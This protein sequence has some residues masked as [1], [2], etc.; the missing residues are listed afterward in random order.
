[1]EIKDSITPENMKRDPIDAL[2]ETEVRDY[3]RTILS[4][5]KDI[6]KHFDA[7]FAWKNARTKND[8]K[9]I[10]TRSMQGLRGAASFKNPGAV[11]RA[12]EPVV[13][14]LKQAETA[15]QEGR[16]EQSFQITQAVLEKL[17]PSLRTTDDSNGWIGAQID[18]A[19]RLQHHLVEY[20]EDRSLSKA[21][22]KW[23]MQ[24][25]P[26]AD[27]AGW[28]CA[29]DFAHLAATL[30]SPKQEDVIEDLVTKMV[31]Q[32][33][34][35]EWRTDF[36]SER[37]TEVMYT[38]SLYHKTD[39]ELERFIDDNLEVTSIREQA[40]RRAFNKNDFQRAVDLCYE[41]V[42][43]AEKKNL[44]GVVN[45]WYRALLDI[46]QKQNDK[47]K[48]IECALFLFNNS[49]FEI[50]YYRLLQQECSNEQ[51]KFVRPSLIDAYAKRHKWFELATIYQ[52]EKAY[53][54]LM[55]V[56]EQ[57]RQMRL[58][59]DFQEHLPPSYRQSLLKLGFSILEEMLGY[60]SDRGH[61]RMVA[62]HLAQMKKSIGGDEIDEFKMELIR[63][64]PAR[65]ALIEELNRI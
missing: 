13:I 4:E 21:M 61:Y 43:Q 55:K 25:A 56:L 22:F 40:V 60:F 10:I 24:S 27:F 37:A 59:E 29:W 57:G 8:F 54:D 36:A 62:N 51:W 33:G 20:V 32:T 6:R 23:F 48:I 28:D 47:K 14:L 7:T 34:D 11:H 64:Y 49:H 3:L 31:N 44:P 46:Y 65:K 9:A 12:M 26:K 53:D 39:E 5:N 2:S 30:A 19:V 38:F 16:Y 41:G 52:E 17:V 45:R 18:D 1:M 58:L 63:K 15:L 50:A 42:E 35:S